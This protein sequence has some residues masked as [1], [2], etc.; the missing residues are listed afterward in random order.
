MKFSEKVL[1]LGAAWG[2]NC[3]RVRLSTVGAK[4]LTD[5]ATVAMCM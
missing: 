2:A 3:D 5:L 1:S 4:N